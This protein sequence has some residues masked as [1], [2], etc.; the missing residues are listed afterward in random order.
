MY[1]IIN[2]KAAHTNSIKLDRTVT[3]QKALVTV[4]SK[5][6]SA[7]KWG[8]QYNSVLKEISHEIVLIHGQYG[9]STEYSLYHR[10]FVLFRPKFTTRV[11]DIKFEDVT[12]ISQ[13]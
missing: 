8:R 4:C 2:K 6:Y 10:Y 3:T 1:I 7:Q 11:L 12:L 5:E 9:S 13:H